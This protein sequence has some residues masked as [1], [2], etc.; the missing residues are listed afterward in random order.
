MCDRFFLGGAP[1]FRGFRTH[2]VGPREPRHA[3][4]GVAPAAATGASARDAV[5]GEVLSVA[6][7]SLSAPLAGAQLRAAGVR[8]QLFGSVGG[9]HAVRELR[10]EAGTSAEVASNLM[11][12]ARACVG[13]GLL[14]PTRLGRLELSLTH[15]LK[16]QQQD[17]VQRS[18]WQIG[19][20][21]TIV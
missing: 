18:G 21:S 7:L 2:G 1:S 13:A 9:L 6:T 8:A 14:I 3:A 12:G 16:R 5:G 15:V 4:S 20:S 19:L 10:G 17:A 11:R